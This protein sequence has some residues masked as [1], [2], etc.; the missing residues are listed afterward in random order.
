MLSGVYFSNSNLGNLK[1]YNKK[2]IKAIKSKPGSA[3]MSHSLGKE[4]RPGEP[5]L[6]ES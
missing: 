4:T 3:L 2:K 1:N 6:R 5:C